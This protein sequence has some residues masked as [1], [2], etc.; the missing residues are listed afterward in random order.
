MADYLGLK[1]RYMDS[2][3]MGGSVYM[4][5]VGHAA[6]A[7][8]AGKCRVALIT[9]GGRPRTTSLRAPGG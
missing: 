5:H 4:S 8:A 3:D 9:L 6:A 2:S 7:I 1:L